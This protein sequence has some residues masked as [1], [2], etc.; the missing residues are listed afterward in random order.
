MIKNEKLDIIK[1]INLLDLLEKDNQYIKNLLINFDLEE[2][3][4]KSYKYFNLYN[5]GISFCMKD[6]KVDFIYLYNKNIMKFNQ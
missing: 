4:V 1:E 3:D 2:R 6:E 5:E